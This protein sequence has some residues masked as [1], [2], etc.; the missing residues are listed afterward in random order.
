MA[1]SISDML[2]ISKFWIIP[3]SSNRASSYQLRH[4]VVKQEKLGRN[5]CEFCISFHTL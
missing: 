3:D 1:L 4:L 5:D 2:C